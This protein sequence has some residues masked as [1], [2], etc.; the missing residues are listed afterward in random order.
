MNFKPMLLGIDSRMK[1]L[2]CTDP[3]DYTST[4]T[5]LTFTP[6]NSRICVNIPITND[7]IVEGN[8]NFTVTVT[9]N[10]TTVQ[11]GPNSNST[12]TIV[13]NDG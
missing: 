3:K 5:D 12:V 1:S 6:D 11:T 4:E 8:E 9:S 13:D 7:R 10:D 2:A